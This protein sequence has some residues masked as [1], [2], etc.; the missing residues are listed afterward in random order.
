MSCNSLTSPP[1]GSHYYICL[2]IC[3]LKLTTIRHVY[4]TVNYGH[5]A[6]S[7]IEFLAYISPQSC[8]CII[9]IP[10]ARSPVALFYTRH[11]N[12]LLIVLNHTNLPINIIWNNEQALHFLISSRSKKASDWQGNSQS[13]GVIKTWLFHLTMLMYVY[14]YHICK[15]MFMAHVW[16][17]T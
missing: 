6:S 2:F 1:Y 3:L 7:Y 12:K 16:V 9:N 4:C 17:I 13:D 8:K 11:F 5:D 10:W 15:A 14:I